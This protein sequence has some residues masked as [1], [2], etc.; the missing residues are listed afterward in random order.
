[1]L[2]PKLKICFLFVSVLVLLAAC[3]QQQLI[4]KIVPEQDQQ[5]AKQVFEQLQQGDYATLE[6]HLDSELQTADIHSTF[7]QMTA[8]FPKVPIQQVNII[9]A[10]KLELPNQTQYHLTFEYEYPQQQWLLNDLI[11]KKKNDQITIMGLHVTPIDA[12]TRHLN[13][14]TFAGK[15]ILNY[16][17]FTLAIIIPIF[18]IYVLIL[19]IRTPMEKRKWLW[20]IFISLGF[21]RILFNWTNG[22]F[23]FQPFSF[24]LL[25]AGFEQTNTYS[26]LILQIALPIGAIIFL[27][28]RRALAV[29]QPKKQDI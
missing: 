12:A 13:D 10:H 26:P 11:F 15:G 6:A 1:M 28:R 7:I 19:C 5:F 17:F 4:N 24:Q 8:Q 3:S 9:G 29:S 18:V 20:L 23:V 21:T 2:L 14:F 25:G 27:Y 16:V 22:Q